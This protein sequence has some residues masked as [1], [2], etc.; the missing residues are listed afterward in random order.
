MF[1]LMNE[2]YKANLMDKNWY[3]VFKD[4]PHIFEKI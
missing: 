4:F 1:Q 2:E 3:D